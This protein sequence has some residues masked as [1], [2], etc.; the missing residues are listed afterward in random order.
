MN[1]AHKVPFPSQVR[2]DS[3]HVLF[4]RVG[5]SS[6]QGEEVVL[7]ESTGIKFRGFYTHSPLFR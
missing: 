5:E 2:E 4:P 1:L 6:Y 7:D 3:S